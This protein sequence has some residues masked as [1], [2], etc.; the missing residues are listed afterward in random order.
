MRREPPASGTGAVAKQSRGWRG[1]CRHTPRQGGR[2]QGESQQKNEDQGVLR[3][4]EGWGLICSASGL[5]RDRVLLLHGV[6]STRL[7]L[8]SRSWARLGPTAPRPSWLPQPAQV[9]ALPSCRLARGGFGHKA[10]LE[11]LGR[12]SQAFLRAEEFTSP[13]A[14]SPLPVSNSAYCSQVDSF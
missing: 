10:A 5:Q 7:W 11:R 12:C 3:G 9:L 13:L 1:S 2:F 8:R 4:R 6:A 14:S